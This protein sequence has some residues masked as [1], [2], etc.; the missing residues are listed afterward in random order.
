MVRDDSTGPQMIDTGLGDASMMLTAVFRFCGQ[1][2]IVPSGVADQSRARM[3]APIWP[4]S[5]RKVCLPVGPELRPRII[6]SAGDFRT[7][8]DGIG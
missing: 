2:S 6:L 7:N 3:S 4:P 5:A 8:N 1:L